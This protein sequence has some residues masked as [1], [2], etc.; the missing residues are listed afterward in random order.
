MARRDLGRF[1]GLTATCLS[2]CGCAGFWDEVTSHNFKFRNLYTTPDPFVVLKESTDGDE[3]A[4]ALRCLREPKYCGG[5]DQDQDAVVKILV[6]AATTEKQALCRLAAIDSLS[7]FRDPRAAAGLQ[8]AFLR[9][10]IGF[11]PDIATR[12]QCQAVR[13][14]GEVGDGSSVKFL[15][16]V[17]KEPPAVGSE[18]EK[19]QLMDVRIAAARAL[20]KFHDHQAEEALVLV[21]KKDKDVA[22]HDCAHDSLQACTGKTIPADF[23]NWDEFMQPGAEKNVDIADG[24]GKKHKLLGLF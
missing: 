6:T 8:E 23:K 2:L 19:Q 17:V 1:A 18:Q 11:P 15:A 7:H 9:S 14:L 22:L 12:I 24:D 21:L 13:G 4:K 16:N 5:S 20:G 3:R 10:N